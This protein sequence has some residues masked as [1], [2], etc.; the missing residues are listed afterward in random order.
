MDDKI[1]GFE[2]KND[3]YSNSRLILAKAIIAGIDQLF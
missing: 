1:S 2:V 3:I